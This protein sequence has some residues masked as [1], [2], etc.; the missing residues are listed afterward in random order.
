MRDMTQR[1]MRDITQ[2]DMRDITQL[3]K[4]YNVRLHT[5]MFLTFRNSA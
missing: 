1:D 4:M 2:R 5:K 3:S